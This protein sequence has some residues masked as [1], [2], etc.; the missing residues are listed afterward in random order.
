[1]SKI[2]NE[3]LKV[4]DIILEMFPELKKYKDDIIVN[5]MQKHLN[6]NKY[7][8]TKYIHNNYELYID[9]YGMIIDKNIIF[10]GFINDNKLYL[11]DDINDNIIK[12][13]INKYDKIM[14]Y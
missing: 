13:D 9:P 14:K 1:M 10:K 7:V 8:F 6:Q 11:T 2:E 4:I 12:L 3:K 5:V